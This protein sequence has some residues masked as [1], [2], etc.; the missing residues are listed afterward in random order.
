MTAP[1]ET[2]RDRI[3]RDGRFVHV[4]GWLTKSQAETAQRWMDANAREVERIAAT[5]GRRGRKPK[6]EGSET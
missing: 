4:I 2:K 1:R 5:P 3:A 6:A